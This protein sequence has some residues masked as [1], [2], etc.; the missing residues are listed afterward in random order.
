MSQTADSLTF[1]TAMHS[2]GSNRGG[3][4]ESGGA[5]AGSSPSANIRRWANSLLTSRSAF[6]QSS[7]DQRR[8]GAT[9]E[10]GEW[11]KIHFFRGMV[12]D[13]RRRAPYYWSDWLDAWDYRVIP[14]TVYMYF[15]KYEPVYYSYVFT[16]LLVN[17]LFVRCHCYLF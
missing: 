15:A 16:Y 9:Q 14:S 11:W 13:L 6:N 12:N 8:H 3:A 10:S 1:P 17:I 5:G 2:S 7:T 4:A